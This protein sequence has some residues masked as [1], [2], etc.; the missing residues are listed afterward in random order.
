MAQIAL[1]RPLQ[2]YFAFA[3]LPADAEGR[4]FT[5]SFPY[6]EGQRLDR[7]QWWW[8][9]SSVQERIGGQEAVARLRQEAMDRFRVHIERWLVTS[10]RRLFDGDPFPRLGQVVAEALTVVPTAPLAEQLA[11]PADKV[12]NG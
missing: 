8:Q 3:E 4:R 6:F 2:D 7:L 12:A 1:P 9:V 10:Q 5:L 11:W